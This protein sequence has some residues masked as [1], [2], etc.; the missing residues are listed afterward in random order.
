MTLRIDERSDAQRTVLCLSGRIRSEH[1]E[2]LRAGIGA[3]AAKTALDLHDVTL[4]D[5]EA[6]RFLDA[7]EAEGTELR[8]CSSYIRDWIL[9]EREARRREAE[10]T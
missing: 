10:K 5:V 8:H 2:A 3:G 7:C 1:L 9:R 6:V 4:V